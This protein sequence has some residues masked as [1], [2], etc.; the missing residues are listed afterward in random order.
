[1]K[2]GLSQVNIL[3]FLAFCEGNMIVCGDL[4]DPDSDFMAGMVFGWCHHHSTN[5]P[6][7]W[8]RLGSFLHALLTQSTYV[9]DN[10]ILN[11]TDRFQA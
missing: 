5:T 4:Q 10:A 1:M 8:S 6:P 7:T 2:R 3:E 11:F 9:L